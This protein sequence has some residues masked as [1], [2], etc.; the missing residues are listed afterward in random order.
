VSPAVTRGH[1][2]SLRVYGSCGIIWRRGCS[3]TT[4]A[5]TRARHCPMGIRIVLSACAHKYSSKY[6]LQPYAHARTPACTHT[7]MHARTNSR[8]HAC[9]YVRTQPPHMHVRT[10]A[11][12]CT[13]ACTHART[14][15]CT[16]ACTYTRTH[17]HHK[18][19]SHTHRDLSL[20][21]VG[22]R[23]YGGSSRSRSEGGGC[24]R[25]ALVLVAE[26]D[27]SAAARVEKGEGGRFERGEAGVEGGQEPKG[28]QDQTRQTITNQTGQKR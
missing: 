2:E 3:A 9:T 1:H 11:H 8:E 10:Q 21:V 7:R 12:T 19:T 15:T 6:A 25:W 5:R 20:L 16:H 17:L 28:A 22:R 26:W 4:R 24:G 23:G 18:H 27:R 14:H 13:H